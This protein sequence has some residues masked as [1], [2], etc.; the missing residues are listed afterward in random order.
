MKKQPLILATGQRLGNERIVRN[1]AKED[2]KLHPEQYLGISTVVSLVMDYTP[3]SRQF[4][5]LKKLEE[6]LFEAQGLQAEFKGVV[7]LDLGSWIGH[8]QEEYLEIML[9]F[10][11]DAIKFYEWQLVFSVRDTPLDRAQSLLR[12]VQEFLPATQL[13]EAMPTFNKA[14]SKED[15]NLT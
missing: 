12:T 7:L 6:T 3:P 4:H 1:W 14:S 2:Q 10:L 11:A 9:A 13:V 15:K 5:E 8:E